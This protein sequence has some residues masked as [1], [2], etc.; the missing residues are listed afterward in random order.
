MKHARFIAIVAAL[1]PFTSA[2]QTNLESLYTE[3]RCDQ[4]LPMI[5]TAI[6]DEQSFFGPSE[7]KEIDAFLL[8]FGL[9]A[10]FEHPENARE[11]IGAAYGA[12]LFFCED[13]PSRTIF[14]LAQR[15][16]RD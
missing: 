8:G 16:F 3:V 14:D 6:N 15:H 5:L 1:Y 2:A 11:A 12:L 4:A 7:A 9:L 10:A 13:E